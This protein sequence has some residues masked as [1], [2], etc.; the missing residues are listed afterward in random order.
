MGGGFFCYLYAIIISIM[1]KKISDL[2]AAI[3]AIAE[4]QGRQ[5]VHQPVAAANV[6]ADYITGKMLEQRVL[7]GGEVQLDGERCRKRWDVLLL[8]LEPMPLDFT[9][10]EAD[11]L[12]EAA[13]SDAV[14]CVRSLSEQ[15]WN[16][17]DVVNINA[18]YD[19]HDANVGGVAATLT[20][21][22]DL[23]CINNYGL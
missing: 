13:W 16:I 4:Q 2:T 6:E 19:E 20:I 10:A 3:A 14:A 9:G 7:T 15:G 23:E 11:R 17:G 8:W 21:M 18:V 1:G 22:G 5:H 12:V